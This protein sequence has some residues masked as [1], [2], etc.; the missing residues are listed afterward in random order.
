V[1]GWAFGPNTDLAAL[2]GTN[3][4]NAHGFLPG[5]VG[6]RR[7][8]GAGRY[9]QGP[10]WETTPG[11]KCL[12]DNKDCPAA[13]STAAPDAT[14]ATLAP[15]ATLAAGFAW[16]H[17]EGVNGS[18]AN[19]DYDAIEAGW[20]EWQA[21]G[22]RFL[23]QLPETNDPRD[24]AL[25]AMVRAALGYHG[26]L[27]PRAG[28]VVALQVRDAIARARE[29]LWRLLGTIACAYVPAAAPGLRGGRLR[30]RHREMRRLLLAH[31]A[32]YDV[33]LDMVADDEYRSALADSRRTPEGI[34]LAAPGVKPTR[35]RKSPT[36]DRG[37]APR[38]PRMPELGGGGGG[39]AIAAVGVAALAAAIVAWRSR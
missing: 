10:V 18:C 15:S 6:G 34:G 30:S 29:Q 17:M 26:N 4:P 5:I 28:V 7:P 16:A 11:K 2:A 8:T 37:P 22:T 38:R 19:A 24:R 35:Q 25:R 1:S 13:S 12:V 32:R 9:F 23:E 21:Q 20:Q 14:T 27:Y 31:P 39:A 36:L 3:E 33:E